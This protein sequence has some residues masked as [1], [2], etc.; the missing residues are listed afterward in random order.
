MKYDPNHKIAFD[1]Q[2]KTNPIFDKLKK[3]VKKKGENISKGKKNNE[4]GV[5]S[6]TQGL[7]RIADN[8]T[9]MRA[10]LDKRKEEI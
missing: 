3:S 9:G 4:T 7:R 6:Q 1:G 2:V 10:S 5:N 8:L